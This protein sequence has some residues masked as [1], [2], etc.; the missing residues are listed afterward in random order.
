MKT[1]FR[2]SIFFTL[3]TSFSFADIIH[4][5]ADIGSIQGGINLAD[6]GDTVL[7]S[8]GTYH[9]NINFYGK[10][11]TVGSLFLRTSDTSYISNT[12]IDGD[13]NGSVA[14]FENG[15]NF[16]ALLT[17]FTITNGSG[18]P[19]PFVGTYGGGIY[20][21]NSNPSL[22]NLI[23]TKNTS[24]EGAGIACQFSNAK[25][26]NNVI[27]NNIADPYW[28]GGILCESSGGVIANNIITNNIAGS[29]GGLEII[30][31][32]NPQIRNNLISNNKALGATSGMGGGIILYTYCSPILKNNVIRDNDA[33]WGGGIFLHLDSNPFVLNNTIVNNSAFYTGGGIYSRFGSNPIVTN[34]ILWN[35]YPENVFFPS[36]DDTNSIICSYSDIQGGEDAIVTNNNGTV[37][38][39]TGNIDTDP[40]FIDT[41]NDDYSLQIGSPCI[42]SGMQD[43]SL[44]YNYSRDT[45][46]IP[47]MAY[48]GNAPDMGAH[49]FGEVSNT[50]LPPVVSLSFS[51]NEIIWGDSVLADA[52]MSYD[53][54][55]DVLEFVWSGN[56][57]INP[58]DNNQ[59]AWI[60]PW[61]TGGISIKHYVN[62]GTSTSDATKLIMVRPD[63]ENITIDNSYVDPDWIR[64][65]Y[66]FYGDTLIVPL[67]PK[68]TTRIYVIV[69]GEIIPTAEIKIPKVIRIYSLRK[70]NL[71]VGLE[72]IT[73]GFWGP[74]PLSI[75]SVVSQWELQP[76]I[77]NYT[78]GEFDINGLFFMDDDTALVYDQTSVYK[79][80]FS[81]PSNPQIL[82]KTDYTFPKRISGPQLVGEYIYIGIND[83]P[84][85]TIEILDKSTFTYIEKLNISPEMKN[86]I[87]HDT[88][89][90]VGFLDSLSLYSLANPLEATH[91]TTLTVPLARGWIPPYPVNYYG[92]FVEYNILT[93]KRWAGVD[94][95]DITNPAIP[96]FIA[97]WY[98]GAGYE[99]GIGM[100]L[101]LNN[102]KY[103]IFDDF[104][105][106]GEPTNIYSGINQISFI[107]T[108]TEKTKSS[109]VIRNLVLFQ[110]YPNPFNPLT[111]I[112]FTLP[113][114]QFVELK[115]YN[116]LG[117]EV[118][119][120][121]SKKLNQGNYTYTFD[122][123]N[124][125]SGVYY[126]QLVAGD[127]K[128]VKKMIL[129][130]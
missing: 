10:N 93:V 62:D 126:Y 125:A 6:T 66:Y 72:G 41:V 85:Y 121:E 39:L 28:G 94:M 109:P 29:G 120:L 96:Q 4:I 24:S 26:I 73:S 69:D 117:E 31:G 43:T 21:N 64:T 84:V 13:N 76:I 68:D 2:A 57:I 115:V 36:S 86:F 87:V 90:A 88:L 22:G 95:F 80:D 108:N 71:Y 47:A 27:K 79:I 124:L 89:M 15:E 38:W 100:G 98:G 16:T 63:L 9:E 114:S 130:K 45:L 34:S 33:R 127:F 19:V 17:G 110:N 14:V 11:I 40:M 82:A 104:D 81:D 75:Y 42:N 113:K 101:H 23:I 32:S 46:Y 111:L 7:V 83:W 56:A 129:I 103:Y 50:N 70:N 74:G 67:F 52:S 102:G 112:E 61:N 116:I 118:T 1:I 128:E 37:F 49:E 77:E 97:S 18:T 5:P 12:I 99:G 78:P 30:M 123:K 60:R 59:K 3:I 105:A 119:T 53:P 91:I 54:D 20:V 48:N 92:N 25:I 65:Q 44:V 122:G 35:N 8:P 58:F 51:Q 107:P 55:N 106:A